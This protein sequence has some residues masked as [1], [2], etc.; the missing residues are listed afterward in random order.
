MWELRT[1]EL[2]I[3][4]FLLLP[5]IRPFF[6]G[7]WAIDGLAILPLLALGVGI[8]IFPAYGIRPE[9]F[10]LILYVIFM[11]IAN[12]S[13]LGAVFRQLKND[14]FRDRGLI[15]SCALLALL[16][17]VTAL[18][19]CFA[20]SL[21]ISLAGSGVRSATV[22][23]EGRK[24]DLF[25]RAY[26][27]EPAYASEPSEGTGT[28]KKRPLMI[29]IPPA[30]GSLLAVDR[31]CEE[32]SRRGFTTLAYSRKGVDAPATQT[33]GRKRLLSPVGNLRLLRAIFQGTRWTRANAIGRALEEERKQ[34]L[35]FLLA[36][37]GN[38]GIGASKEAV[39]KLLGDD[40]DRNVVFI[41]GY[42]AGGGAATSL[43]AEPGFAAQNPSVRGIIG[44]ES[45]ILSALEQAPQKIL[46][47]SQS[48]EGRLR[49]F[50]AYFG[51][52]IANLG[53]KRLRGF[54][55][56]PQ[57][58]VPVLFILSDRA[59]SYSWRQEQRYLGVMETYRRAVN[60]VAL[61][62]VS[63]AGPLDYSDVPEKYPLLSRI[64]PGES[65]PLWSRE[66]YLDGTVSLIA[67]FSAAL[68]ETGAV[69]RT[70]LDSHIH[71]DVNRAWN[72]APAK[73]ILGL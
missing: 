43:S 5:L 10:P 12:R 66:E 37:L 45:P 16:V 8:G 47:A 4:F 68:M 35:A 31:L 73:Y 33:N 7:F 1:L 17:A 22:R 42:G 46:D 34:D 14:D 36:S 67:N 52:K 18:A 65:A 19:V 70:L 13:A 20:P 56:I 54:D 15:S 27:P 40:T 25:L 11:N 51:T 9:C 44:L 63:G 38:R 64:F 23:D 21:D 2:L 41:A 50:L 61:V 39:E 29:L 3:A 62:M 53:P 72:L 6:K 48:Q 30:A 59:L 49:Y 58:E 28:A 71:V 57:P 55:R 60:P 69:E 24:V 26:A 32:L